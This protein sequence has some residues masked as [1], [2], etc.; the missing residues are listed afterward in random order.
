MGKFKKGQ[1]GNPGGRP[2]ENQE[3][4]ELARQHTEEAVE[5]LAYWMR[6]PEAKASVQACVQMLNRGWGAPAQM[7]GSDPDNPIRHIHEVIE[8]E[9]VRP[10][11]ANDTDRSEA[12][13]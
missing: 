2:K 6:S 5:R 10:Q 13:H 12:I 3:V 9:I 7:V 11:L 4:R 8:R 1:S